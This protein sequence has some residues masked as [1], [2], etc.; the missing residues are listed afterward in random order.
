MGIQR[1]DDD[2]LVPE[3]I[4]GPPVDDEHVAARVPTNR[5]LIVV[6]LV[7][8]VASL[9][10]GM[11]A[12]DAWQNRAGDGYLAGIP[13]V[14]E[15]AWNVP[16]EEGFASLAMAREVGGDALL[17]DGGQRLRL[18]SL[19]GS[20]S[21]LRAHDA[22]GRQIWEYSVPEGHVVFAQGEALLQSDGRT[23]SRLR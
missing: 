20:G 9:V 10:G 18:I 13:S 3:R 19:D 14:P 4:G 23:L 7:V 22:G 15:V 16:L 1:I 12:Y 17:L 5:A 2:Q 11:L 21:T 8:T 6:T